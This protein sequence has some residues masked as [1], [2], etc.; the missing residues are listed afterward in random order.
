VRWVATSESGLH[1]IGGHYISYEYSFY[2]DGIQDGCITGALIWR[3]T[4]ES[5]FRHIRYVNGG[6]F[7]I[8]NNQFRGLFADDEGA[9]T[10]NAVPVFDGSLGVM[11]IGNQFANLVNGIV[12]GTTA[13]NVYIGPNNY[14]RVTNPQAGTTPVS[15]Y[16]TQGNYGLNS[17]KTLTGGGATEN[18]DIALPPGQ[19]T[20][21]PVSGFAKCVTSGPVFLEGYYDFTASTASSARFIV[22]NVDGGTLGGGAYGFSVFLTG[23][24]RPF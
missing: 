15:A 21:A 16:V 12:L 1:V 2:L 11:I 3:L 24:V 13:R 7:V 5:T 10:V 6:S 19:F 22:R 18:I 4:G 23:A 14:C 20:D 17:I 8:A 9:I